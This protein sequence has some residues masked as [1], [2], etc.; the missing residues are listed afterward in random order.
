[1]EQFTLDEAQRWIGRTVMAKTAWNAG[2]TPMAAEQ[3]GTVIGVQGEHTLQ[4]APFLC[5]VVQLWPEKH[6][7]VPNVLFVPKPTFN[8]HLCLSHT[9]EEPPPSERD[10]AAGERGSVAQAG[11]PM[12]PGRGTPMAP[13][14][15]THLVQQ[16]LKEALLMQG[17]LEEAMAAKHAE[18]KQVEGSPHITDDEPNPT[19]ASTVQETHAS[20]EKIWRGLREI[21]TELEKIT[22]AEQHKRE[23]LTSSA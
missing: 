14:Q 12:R 10:P 6:G 20:W 15:R 1:M 17:V 8:K 5:L 23:W 3:Q 9:V 2:S 19:P 16:L 11:W 13:R 22:H 4:G 21:H 18:G 7:D